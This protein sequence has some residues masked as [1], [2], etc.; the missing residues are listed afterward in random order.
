MSRKRRPTA[1]TGWISLLALVFPCDLVKAQTTNATCNYSSNNFWLFNT[2]KE[3]PWYVFLE[4]TPR[5]L[6]ILLMMKYW[7]ARCGQNC[8]PCVSPRHHSS[9]SRRSST[10]LLGTLHRLK[11]RNVNAMSSAMHSWRGVRGGSL[12]RGV[13]CESRH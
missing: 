7:P 2:N 11:A 10:R 12:V 3:S 13:Y 1:A 9:T 8:N 6:S 5:P 4:T